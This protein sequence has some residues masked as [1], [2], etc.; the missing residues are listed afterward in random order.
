GGLFDAVSSLASGL[1]PPP[2]GGGGTHPMA[3]GDFNGDGRLDIAIADSSSGG[4]GILFGNGDGTFTLAPAHPVIAVAP[5]DLAAAGSY[6]GVT[7]VGS[8]TVTVTVGAVQSS[9]AWDVLATE[10]PWDESAGLRFADLNGD[11]NPDLLS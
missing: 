6:L 7:D 11:G 10:N 8:N 4:L 1:N 3:V 2:D 5:Q 9:G